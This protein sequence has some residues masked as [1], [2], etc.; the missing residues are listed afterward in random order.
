MD[1]SISYYKEC[2]GGSIDTLCRA[3]RIVNSRIKISVLLGV[4]SKRSFLIA[5]T[6]AHSVLLKMITTYNIEL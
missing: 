4:D 2:L 1:Q 5:N 3:Q 6:H